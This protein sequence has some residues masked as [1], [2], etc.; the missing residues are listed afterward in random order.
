[1]E[2]PCA[3]AAEALYAQGAVWNS[4]VFTTTSRGL[5]E[6]YEG[7]LPELLSRL[8]VLADRGATA[9]ELAELYERLPTEDFSSKLLQESEASLAVI[10]VPACG[11]TDLGTPE[12]VVACLEWFSA[13]R[14]R[15]RRRSPSADR[16]PFDLVSAVARRPSS[17]SD[18]S[19]AARSPRD[20]AAASTAA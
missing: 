3:A 20:A 2:K 16:S 7:R 14:S 13:S 15:S 6:L 11:W 4:F 1:V 9:C 5:L 19:V 18:A 10:R 8:R 12:R 17:W